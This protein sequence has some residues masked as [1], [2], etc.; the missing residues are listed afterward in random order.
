MPSI[1]SLPWI[2]GARHSGLAATV[3]RV[4]TWISAAI[5]GLPF[6][7]PQHWDKRAQNLRNRSRHHR[8]TVSG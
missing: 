6:R 5:A 8:T 4:N 3:R 1:F 7:R 2:R